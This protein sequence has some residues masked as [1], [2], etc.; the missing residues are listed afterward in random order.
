[1]RIAHICLAN[2]YIEGF[3]YQENILPRVHSRMGHEV[4]IIASTETY[5]D[6]M[7]L[8]HVE[9]VSY[10]NGDGIPVCRLPYA[11][12]VPRPLRPKVRAYCGLKEELEAF[13]PDLIFLHDIQ[14]WD[15]LIVRRYARENGIPVHADS[16]TDF[17]NSA[18]GFVSR[19]LLHGLLYRGL[20][21]RADSVI[22]RYYPTLPARADF[23]HEVY[24]LARAKMKL[25][26]FGF[27]DTSVA[28]LDRDAVRRQTRAALGIPDTSLVLVTGGKLDLR[29]NIHTLVER[30]SALRHAGKL[31]NVH[32]VVFGRPNAEVETELTKIDVDTNVHLLGWMKAQE[33]YTVFWASDVAIFPGTHSVVW[34][35]AIGLGL[36]TVFRRWKGMEHL[37]L[38]GNAIFIDNADTLTL[39]NLLI[40]L[41]NDECALIKRMTSEAK[42]KG[43][44]VF[45]FTQIAKIAIQ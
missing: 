24:G 42:E 28:G 45:S 31:A 10:I 14:F 20:A 37:D 11:R 3:G 18:R 6:Q 22:R 12:W 29:K 27:D 7:R 43:P 17:V 38:G 5:I 13:Q 40:D 1:M 44:R 36:A 19:H 32:L 21:R 30:F 39:D 9:A 2:F 41:T 8:G 33:L 15:I 16:H 25:L 23:M 34:E 35:E 4:K 26:P